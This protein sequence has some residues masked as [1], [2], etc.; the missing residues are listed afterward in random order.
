M[1]ENIVM[2]TY[3]GIVQRIRAMLKAF[4]EP[5][6][7]S[8]LPYEDDY[9]AFNTRQ[10]RYA[11]L[12]AMNENTTYSNI[13]KWATLYRTRYG[14]YKFIR[15][16]YNP[17]NRIND[18][19][20][21][22]IFGGNLDFEKTV[23]GAIP[24]VYPT[25]AEADN[26]NTEIETSN[27]LAF[28][29]AK[30]WRDSSWQIRK[31]TIALWGSALGDVGVKVVDDPTKGKVYLEVIHPSKIKTV[32]IDNGHVKSYSLEYPIHYE[33][34]VVMYR[35]ECVN[36][37]DG[38]ETIQYKT[39]KDNMPFGF[40]GKPAEW[41]EMYGFVPFVLIKHNDVGADW[42]WAEVHP[43]RSKIHELDDI[44]S[45]MHDQIRKSVDPVW[46]ANFAKP[47]VAPRAE[48]TA[49][50]TD[51]PVAGREDVPIIYIPETTA[52]M[53]A[54]IAQVDLADIGLELD[55]VQQ[56]LENDYPELSATIWD[57]QGNIASG[58]AIGKARGKVEKK[59]I[60][61]RA[62]YDNAMV[63]LHQMAVAIGGENSYEGYVGFNLKSY[64]DGD[65]DHWID[66]NR[67]IF[68]ESFD[69]KIATQSAFW[70]M[71][72]KALDAG[73]PM[74]EVLSDAGWSD[75]KIKKYIKSKAEADQKTADAQAVLLK[76]KGD[77]FP[78]NKSQ[79]NNNIP[80]KNAQPVKPISPK[81]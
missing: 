36:V 69:G 50:T 25:Q 7:I 65:L 79:D 3:N 6:L 59:V 51:R 55:R 22:M 4:R 32:S 39:F 2:T 64:A 13:H 48:L 72:N 78:S 73:A 29:I 56:E 16:I 63:Q 19:W 35:E 57:D 53:T 70:D 76:T 10:L 52:A 24:L 62:V 42:G 20:R 30:L 17:T 44:A 14:L 47:S 45:K 8:T 61:R 58:K 41:V 21:M 80:D 68:D 23:K 15:H 75:T 49:P 81:A 37:Q 27:P 9:G 11:I 31:G 74:E 12:W 5:D 46:L 60:E 33:N 77:N 43:A 26:I 40:G 67:P 34:T 38:T 54:L 66:P 71:V 28:A 18:F 1:A